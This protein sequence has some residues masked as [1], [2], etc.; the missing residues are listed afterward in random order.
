MPEVNEAS[1]EER[2]LEEK[3]FSYKVVWEKV[4]EELIEEARKFWVSEGALPE[5]ASGGSRANQLLGVIRDSEGGLA[6]VS[7]VE[8][9][10]VPA[11]LNNLFYY[12]RCFVASNY[13]REGLMM[14]L[15]D[16]AREY[17]Y[18]LFLQGENS[19]AKGFY[20]SLENKGL[21]SSMNDA[22]LLSGGLEHS[23]IGVDKKQ[24]RLYVGWFD[25][26]TID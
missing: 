21:E 2:E 15:A 8:V 25:G 9:V 4:S 12:F 14:E 24:R 7:T 11:L 3:G 23:F 19:E 1:V 6:A 18:P 5:G 17:F 22:V 10:P 20:F 16:K 13:R 26:A